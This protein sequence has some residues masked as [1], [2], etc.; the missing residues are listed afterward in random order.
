MESSPW[1]VAA[2]KYAIGTKH[3]GNITNIT[4]Y[5]A[6]VELEAGIEGLV[7]VS[8]MSWTKKNTHPNKIVS[9][10]QEV[11]VQVLSIDTDKHRLSLGVK[12]CQSNP[13]DDFA[14][15]YKKGDLLDGEVRSITDFGL[16]VGLD[17]DVD[18]LV[19]ISDIAWSGADQAIKEYKKG[20]AVK[21]QV[22]EIESGKE[23]V[24][25]GIKQLAEKPADAVETHAPG[26]GKVATFT[27]AAVNENGIEV[28]VSEGV[29]AKIV[30]VEKNGV[31]K[32]SIKAMEQDAEKKA[33]ADYGSADSGASLG[34]IL[35]VALGAAQEE[36][37]KK[38]SKKKV[39]KAEG[40]D[41]AAEAKKPAKKPAA[42]K[43]A[44]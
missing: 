5:G 9:V 24:S 39:E 15:K 28:T 6:F 22:L 13:W 10:G 18:G 3:K 38:S 16:F 43:K 32:L 11:E 4:D 12:Q 20:Q 40:G 23:R 17:G 35:G 29:D 27:V 25:L 31:P 36:A 44:E 30:G 1:E 14:A 19:H 41:D 8:E 7:H 33:I 21:V 2:V 26:K 37:A 34:G 42:K